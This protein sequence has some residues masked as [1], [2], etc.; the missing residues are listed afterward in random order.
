[1]TELEV[2][3]TK[4]HKYEFKIS[5]V[6]ES[7]KEFDMVAFDIYW[8][9]SYSDY[10]DGVQTVATAKVIILSDATLGIAVPTM[11]DK[12]TV[13]GHDWAVREMDSE[14]RTGTHSL[15]CFRTGDR[16]KGQNSRYR[17]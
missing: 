2:T 7:I 4:Y 9:R 6:W 5:E 15:M 17:R 11:K 8:Y 10:Q 16:Q 3:A 13:N 14:I 1:M 12:V